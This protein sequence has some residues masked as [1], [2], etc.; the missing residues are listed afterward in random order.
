V[1]QFLRGDFYAKLFKNTQTKFHN[2]LGIWGYELEITSHYWRFSN[3]IPDNITDETVAYSTNSKPDRNQFS[4]LT[5]RQQRQLTGWKTNVRSCLD[6]GSEECGF[7]GCAVVRE[8]FWHKP[9]CAYDDNW[10]EY[11]YYYCSR[12]KPYFPPMKD[13]AFS[14]LSNGLVAL[15]QAYTEKAVEQVMKH[16][17]AK[18]MREMA[19]QMVH[20]MRTLPGPSMLMHRQ[21]EGQRMA[22][23]NVKMGTTDAA[24]YMMCRYCKERGHTAMECPRNHAKR[25]APE[26]EVQQPST[27]GLQ[28][29]PPLPAPRRRGHIAGML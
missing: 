9:L 7:C 26:E 5:F 28:Q 3:S 23:M 25:S 11:G 4:T 19:M 12:E 14:I 22:T 20:G 18:A 8:Y 24:P 27:S 29:A 13:E 1:V 21:G 15:K 16:Y 6:E 17:G 10:I 2:A